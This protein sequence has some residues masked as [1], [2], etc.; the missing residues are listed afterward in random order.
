ML[1]P[2]FFFVTIPYSA[3]SDI[4][5][6][7]HIGP[8]NV[9]INIL[10]DKDEIEWDVLLN[11][12]I[13]YN[14][15]FIF[16]ISDVIITEK[17]IDDILPGLYT[18]FSLSS[19]YFKNEKS[20]P[21]FGN[22]LESF[23]FCKNKVVD[24]FQQQGEAE[25]KLVLFQTFQSAIRQNIFLCDITE[26]ELIGTNKWDRVIDMNIHYIITQPITN[27]TEKDKI[28][29]LAGNVTGFSSFG[30]FLEF[31]SIVVQNN[32]LKKQNDLWE[33][34]ANLYLSFISL[35]KE[36]GETEYRDLKKWYEREYERL[37]LWY[38]RVGHIVN[39][40]SGKRRFKSLF[41][42]SVKRYHD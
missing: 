22:S 31:N 32:W 12:T 2:V 27:E 38:K 42:D 33:M 26:L 41:D 3:I 36:I 5:S 29:R 40:I 10:L 15:R 37:P 18:L 1:R 6:I 13:I 4:S 25:I 39:V 16:S 30:K 24:Y 19:G 11:F 21:V 8:A 35:S 17:T 7:S 20:I 9:G 34:R 14:S 23:T 28:E